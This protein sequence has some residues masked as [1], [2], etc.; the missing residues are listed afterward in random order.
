MQYESWID[1]QIREAAERG[2]F[3]NLPGTGKPLDLDPDENWWIK[4]KIKRENL[5]VV[6]PGPLALRR[7]VERIQDTLATITREEHARELLEDLNE[8]IRDHYRRPSSGPVIVVRLVD[9]EAELARWREARS[10]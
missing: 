9:I 1:R 2:A 10:G 4:A 5:D 8:R 6:L 3:D 7:E